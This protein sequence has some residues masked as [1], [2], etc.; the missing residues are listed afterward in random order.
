M[1]KLI[2]FVLVTIS[3]ISSVLAAG[4]IDIAYS[5]YTISKPGSYIVV[6]DLTT[7]QNLNCISIATGNVTIDLNGHTL[8]GAGTT[9]GT[10][11]SGIYDLNTVSTNNNITILNGTIRDFCYYGIYL[12][13][14]HVQVSRVNVTYNGADGIVLSNIGS[15][16]DC[17][18]SNNGVIGIYATGGGIIRNNNVSYNGTDGIEAFAGAVINENN[19][20]NNLSDGIYCADATVTNNNSYNNHGNGIYADESC[21]VEN[22][23]ANSNYSYGINADYSRVV[24][25]Y[26]QNNDIA[27]I[28]A[29]YNTTIENNT[30]YD[31]TTG[32]L[33]L[34]PDNFISGNRFTQV[35]VSISTAS[36]N[37]L[38]NGS[39]GFLNITF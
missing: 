39:T 37:T 25:N 21:L 6:K 4:Q 27:G 35:S 7:A 12:N 15:I 38:S 28:R 31:T 16:A 36:G 20:S 17:D 24:G 30:L 9:V 34:G 26:C 32:I 5:P 2:V 29:V 23:N 18:V 13:G 1:K 8:Y 10:S 19:V 11:G 33:V 3:S 22:N 14:S